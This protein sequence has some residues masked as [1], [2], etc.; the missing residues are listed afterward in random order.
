MRIVVMSDSHSYYP[1]LQKIFNAQQ[2]ADFF[3][4]L[5]DGGPDIWKLGL[6]FPDRTL[7]SLRGNCDTDR[8]LPD[9]L[10]IPAGNHKIFA[11]HGHKH[12]IKYTKNHIVE[13]AIQNGCDIALF[14][15]THERFESVVNGVHLLNPGSCSI[16]RDGLPRSYAFIDIIGDG[17][18]TNIISL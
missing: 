12:S 8:E 17:I 13:A 15:H 16:P 4:H 1:P 18:V 2:N 3:I 7:Y 6:E 14:G 9:F 5:G 10:V 11:C